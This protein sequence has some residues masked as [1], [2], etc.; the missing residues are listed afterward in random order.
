MIFKKYTIAL[1]LIVILFL[2]FPINI[3]A[4]QVLQVNSSSLL[5]IGDRNRTYTV[6]L[7]CLEVSPLEEEKAIAWLKSQ[8]KG[9]KRVNLKPEGVTNGILLARVSLLNSQIDLAEGL[10]K[11]GIGMKIC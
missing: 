8:V 11:E 1:L 9:R 3:F 2:S 5:R 10:N 7:S 4:A 6:K